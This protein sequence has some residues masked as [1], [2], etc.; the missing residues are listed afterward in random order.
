MRYNN[1]SVARLIEERERDRDRDRQR[2]RLT[3]TD[4]AYCEG[5]RPIH[6]EGGGG[7][8]KMNA[9]YTSE[10]MF[11]DSMDDVHCSSDSTYI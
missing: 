11:N 7:R 2:Q 4:T 6:K 10:L 1:Y 3:D 9:H 8:G 5:H